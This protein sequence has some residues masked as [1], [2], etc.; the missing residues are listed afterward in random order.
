MLADLLTCSQSD[1]ATPMQFKTLTQGIVPFTVGWVGLPMSISIIKT[2]THKPTK[3]DNLSLKFSSQKSP[4]C[5]M[6][7]KLNIAIT[8]Q[9]K[10]KSNL[11]SHS[12][13]KLCFDLLRIK[14]TFF[15]HSCQGTLLLIPSLFLIND[16]TWLCK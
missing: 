6:L 2:T 11:G 9:I 1:L 3:V 7:A 14:Y 10:R 12:G 8:Q 16:L 5:V 4:S 15:P 13:L